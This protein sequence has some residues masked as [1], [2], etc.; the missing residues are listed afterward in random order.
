MPGF[1]LL[2]VKNPDVLLRPV[3]MQTAN[4]FAVVVIEQDTEIALRVSLDDPLGIDNG[5]HNG[6][7][8]VIALQLFQS[9]MT[10]LIWLTYFNSPA[11]LM[12]ESTS[13]ADLVSFVS[14][15]TEYSSMSR[16]SS[17]R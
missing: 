15:G 16:R 13:N 10:F 2:L 1:N 12:I 11:A 9:A 6:A 17:S 14:S 4:R 3:E 7:N 8:N 5:T